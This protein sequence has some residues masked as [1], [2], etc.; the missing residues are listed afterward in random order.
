MRVTAVILGLFGGLLMAYGWWGLNTVAGQQRY[1]EFAGIIP[2]GL[3]WLGLLLAAVGVVV[4]LMAVVKM[5]EV[6]AGT[7]G[8]G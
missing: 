4:A 5:R 1:R 2:A 8:G 3:S 6:A 7:R